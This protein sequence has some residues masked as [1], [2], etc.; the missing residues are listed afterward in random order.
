[1]FLINMFQNTYK[2]K[3]V[4]SKL[5]RLK[6]ITIIGFTIFIYAY[7]MFHKRCHFGKGGSTL[8]IFLL[9][10]T[11]SSVTVLLWGQGGTLGTGPQI[12]PSPAPPP[13]KFLDTVVLLLVEL[14]IGSIVNF[15]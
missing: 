2:F 13:P 6:E 4:L 12:L 9:N 5:P 10:C 8:I 1:M 11:K 15:A 3:T 14:I 7:T